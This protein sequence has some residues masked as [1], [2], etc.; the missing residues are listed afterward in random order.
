M[1]GSPTKECVTLQRLIE[2]MLAPFSVVLGSTLSNILVTAKS[3]AMRIADLALIV[4]P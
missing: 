4:Q 2:L 1:D 3:Y